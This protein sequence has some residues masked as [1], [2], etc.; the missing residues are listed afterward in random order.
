MELADFRAS[1]VTWLDANREH[2]PRDYG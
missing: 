2:A 1:A